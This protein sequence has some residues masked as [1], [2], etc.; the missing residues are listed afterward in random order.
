MYPTLTG[1]DLEITFFT[2]QHFDSQLRTIIPPLSELV[3]LVSY[4]LAMKQ[5]C[6]IPSEKEFSLIYSITPLALGL[7]ELVSPISFFGVFVRQ[8]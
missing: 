4:L 2:L 1:W 3:T 6:F 7:K 8:T 5:S